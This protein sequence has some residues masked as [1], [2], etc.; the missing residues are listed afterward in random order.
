MLTR[1]MMFGGTSQTNQQMLSSLIMSGLLFFVL[2]GLLTAVP[3]PMGNIQLQG[4]ETIIAN[5]GKMFVT[6][7]LIPF[8]LMAVLLLVAFAGAIMLA[9]DR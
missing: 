7:Y 4:G 8:E 2:V 6:S 1:G 5:L 3:W 9:R